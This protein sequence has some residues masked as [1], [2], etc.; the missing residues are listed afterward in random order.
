MAGGTRAELVQ[1]AIDVLR[2]SG[3]AGASARRIAQRAGVNQ[4]LVFYHFGSVNDLLMAALEEVSARRMAA[5]RELLDAAGTLAE[6]ITS[7]RSVF[8]ADLD[9]GH[10]RVLTEMI[11]G[12]QSVP[13]LGD[14]VAACL[15]PWRDFATVAVGDVL[16]TSPVAALLPAE[17]AAHAVVAGLLGLEMLASLD[18]DRTA[19]LALFD[20]ALV[21]GDALDR[22]RPLVAL[23]DL[24]GKRKDP[25]GRPIDTGGSRNRPAAPSN[26]G[27][28]P[29]KGER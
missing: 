3:F 21:A 28:S 26:P 11:S 4:A 25:G 10:V 15:A 22:L 17:E 9:A 2:E 14:R 27:E 1:A 23:L 16:A 20:R 12:A 6:L 5:Y 18:G 8:E 24:G 29:E 7:A 19:A 13:G